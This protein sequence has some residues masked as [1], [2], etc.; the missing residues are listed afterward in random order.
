MIVL[1]FT[2]QN[3]LILYFWIICYL[4]RSK[5][6]IQST[7]QA[8]G[9]ND[10]EAATHGCDTRVISDTKTNVSS[11]ERTPFLPETN[12]SIVDGHHNEQMYNDIVRNNDL[13]WLWIVA[14]TICH[15]FLLRVN[16]LLYQIVLELQRT[17]TKRYIV[18]FLE[19][20]LLASHNQEVS[21][22]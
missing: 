19:R 22:W 14:Y 7:P 8:T 21:Y 17:H 11:S 1:N 16:T 5:C 18:R 13:D 6:N 12:C 3:L 20:Q 10:I 9:G 2:I 4:R 15:I